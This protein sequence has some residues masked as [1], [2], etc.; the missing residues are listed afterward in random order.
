MEACLCPQNSWRLVNDN[1]RTKDSGEIENYCQ[2]NVRIY[3]YVPLCVRLCVC[4]CVCMCVRA[5]VCLYL[6]IIVCGRI[7][8]I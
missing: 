1:Q 4:V 5:H 7:S 2:K 8:D 6:R 3:I